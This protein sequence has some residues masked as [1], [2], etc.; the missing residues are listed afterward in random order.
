[1]E[2][3]YDTLGLLGSFLVSTA[4]IPQIVK[5]YRFKS[6][7]DISKTFQSVFVVS[8]ACITAYGIGEGL[9]PIWIPSMLELLGGIILLIMKHYYDWCDSKRVESER[10]EVFIGVVTEEAGVFIYHVLETNRNY[11]KLAITIR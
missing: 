2:T 3:F 8:I 10:D 11:H 1:M 4:L 7:K 6:A 9:W 5:V